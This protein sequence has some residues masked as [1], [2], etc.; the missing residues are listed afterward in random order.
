MPYYPIW[1]LVYIGIA[2]VVIYGLTPHFD[3]EA[4]TEG[5]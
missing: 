2:V 4:V 1:S 5:S 3:E